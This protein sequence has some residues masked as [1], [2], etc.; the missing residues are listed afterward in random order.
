M[1]YLTQKRIQWKKCLKCGVGLLLLFFFSSFLFAAPTPEE[2]LRRAYQTSDDI[3]FVGALKITDF[4]RGGIS[5]EVKV[6]SKGSQLR[7]EYQRSRSKSKQDSPEF[8]ILDNGKTVYRL[9]VANRTAYESSVKKSPKRLDLLF[10]NYQLKSVSIEKLLGRPTVLISIEPKHSGNPSKKIWI[11]QRTAVILR[12]EQYSS[13]GNLKA[14]SF[15]THVDFGVDVK[16][17]LFKLPSNWQVVKSPAEAE[18]RMSRQEIC[19]AVGFEVIEPGSLPEGYILDGFY[20]S[21]CPMGMPMAHLRYFDGLNSIS[22][23]EH[24][25][26]CMERGRSMMGRMMCRMHGGKKGCGMPVENLQIKKSFVK[27]GLMF[28]FVGDLSEK[29]LQKMAL[30]IE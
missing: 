27:N 5:T 17:E 3:Q 7:M 25:T 22:L 20:L 18:E 29:Q 19:Q 16:E 14:L 4:T 30:S 15:Y 2:M 9:K 1:N 26:N 23:F 11:D 10:E 6:F 12:S 21:Y 8:V 28:V 13:D 24:P